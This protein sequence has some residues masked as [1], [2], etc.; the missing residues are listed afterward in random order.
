V[1]ADSTLGAE[2]KEIT[3]TVSWANRESREV[4]LTTLVYSG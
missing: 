1:I 4:I 3:V 2:L